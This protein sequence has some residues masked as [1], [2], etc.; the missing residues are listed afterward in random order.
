MSPR[1]MFAASALLALGL[2]AC[3]GASHLPLDPAGAALI[4]ADGPQAGMLMRATIQVDPSG[5]SATV[6]P[7]RE[8][9]AQPPQNFK[10]DLDISHFVKPVDLS[11]SRV[12][13]DSADDLYLELRHAHPFPAPDLT[14]NPS[15]KNRCDLSY[16]GRLMIL[17]DQQHRSFFAGDAVI[18]PSLVKG[19]DGYYKPGNLLLQTGLTNT[20]FPYMLLVDEEKDNRDGITN[21]GLAHGTY[22]PAAGGW[23]RGNLGASG[24]GWTGYDYLHAGQASFIALR[25][26]RA[27]LQSVNYQFDVAIMVQWTDPR[28]AAG[29]AKRFPTEPGDVTQFAYRLPYA[30]LD[31]SVI[32]PPVPVEL[33]SITG[34][35]GFIACA[36]R[37][38]DALSTMA[39]DANLGN[40]AN[41]ALNRPGHSGIPTVAVDCPDVLTAQVTL[42]PEGGSGEPGNTL[43]YS[44][45][46][47]NAQVAPAGTYLALIRAVDPEQGDTDADNYHAGVDPTTILPD[48]ARRLQ[49]KTFQSFEIHVVDPPQ[50]ERL[51]ATALNQTGPN[52]GTSELVQLLP[53]VASIPHTGATAMV[54][55]LGVASNEILDVNG[56]GF[57]S[58][59]SLPDASNRTLVG[60]GAWRATHAS[61]APTGQDPYLGT[62]PFVC[63][64]ADVDP[65]V[66][67]VGDAVSGELLTVLDGLPAALPQ[68]T[69]NDMTVYSDLAGPDWFPV[70]GSKVCAAL[71]DGIVV[72]A[73]LPP[74]T[75]RGNL[76]SGDLTTSP[77]VWT[78]LT[79]YTGSS[80]GAFYPDWGPAGDKIVFLHVNVN[81]IDL[82]HSFRIAIFTVGSGN[83]TDLNLD[84]MGTPPA[85]ATVYIPIQPVYNAAG[86]KIA[87]A[88]LEAS[89]TAGAIYDSDIWVYDIG[90]GSV[91]NMTDTDG[92]WEAYP[93]FR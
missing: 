59:L 33:T 49:F 92:V 85:P 83:V 65:P 38:W 67:A 84:G 93:A 37:D 80:K 25:L 10:Y 82:P 29:V 32:H 77:A 53:S 70:N 63:L 74:I 17:A 7:A 72:Q 28:G 52:A 26:H 5:L 56:A 42:N 68:L 31:G 86:T 20:A 18:D 9:S 90:S 55:F 78:Q 73:G 44:G 45:A 91:T 24:T 6:I 19:P 40:K 88:A 36:V 60:A 11:V 41:V 89:I 34:S 4:E 39:A 13:F 51:L 12:A 21:N 15:G 58:T 79:S 50:P 66:L 47:E 69:A 23:Q 54:D 16:T 14:K 27:A 2:A 76:F 81:I 75:A 3:Q 1:S 43:K 61:V 57:L 35:L 62:L 64:R 30:A 8:G 22:D 71:G 48:K 46:L 87:F